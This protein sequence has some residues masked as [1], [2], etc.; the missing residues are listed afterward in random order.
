M[1]PYQHTLDEVALL[2]LYI[3]GVT[4]ING[5]DPLYPNGFK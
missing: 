1:P 4:V 3:F 5:M 2:D